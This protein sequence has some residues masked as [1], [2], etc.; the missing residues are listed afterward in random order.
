MH[1]EGLFNRHSDLLV[2]H[3]GTQTVLYDAWHAA[4]RLPL[5]RIDVLSGG[6]ALTNPQSLYTYPWHVLFAPYRPE[7]VIGLVIWLDLV[8][9]ALGAY[10]AATV[11]RLSVSARLLVAIATLFSFKTILAV[12]A[13]WLTALPGIA[14]IPWLLG[15]AVAVLE[16]PSWRSALFLGLVGAVSLHTG[17]LQQVYY[18]GLLLGVWSMVRLAQQAATAQYG[19]ATRTAVCL[20]LGAIMAFSLSAYLIIPL[21][22][23][24][25]LVTRSAGSYG[26]FIGS[27]PFPVRALLTLLDPEV[28]GTPL[29]GTFIEAWEYVIYLGAIPSL[30]A[31]VGA[32]RGRKRPLVRVLSAGL[33]LTVLLALQTPL[34]W[35]VYGIVPGYGL[36]RLPARIL[37]VSA[38]F[39]FCLAG[40]GLD[41]ILS[42]AR[43]DRSRRVVAVV[44]IGLVCVEGT[45]W[46]RR[47]LRT[48]APIPPVVAAP[49]LDV[50][51]TRDQAARIAPLSR[52]IPNYGSAASLG[53][54]LVAGGDPFNLRH[55]QTY[56]DLLQSNRA[57]GNRPAGWTDV[58]SVARLDMLAALNVLYVVAPTRVALPTSEYA[59]VDVFEDQAQFRFYEGVQSGPVYIYR[60][61]RFLGRAFFATDVR[62]AA[63]ADEAVRLIQTVDV[64]E[65]AIVEASDAGDSLATAGDRVD[66][67]RS[68]GGELDLAARNSTRRFL[69]ISEVWHPGWRARMDGQSVPLYRS[70]IALQGVWLTP[71][72]HRIEL[73]Y[74]PPGLT[75]GLTIT[76]FT[77][78][79]VV[80]LLVLAVMKRP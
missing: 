27:N 72:E 66:V 18:I 43:T 7:R 40:V 25:A 13:G 39:G 5:W 64:R 6:P 15:S 31:I 70:D 34:L 75:L 50:L 20:L 80:G 42:R 63:D 36:F 3:L 38:F 55:Y 10:Y 37:F 19:N 30:L 12:Y 47:Y 4:H 46:A 29:D 56:M 65:T 59:L 61:Q 60:N 9:A 54:Q 51:T 45:V 68:A 78:T 14:A 11:L 32:A 8:V 28:F 62:T 41:E 35:I 22:R 79:C 49:Y 57:S 1:P 76:A 17:H 73:R 69:V 52:S 44:L 2:Y 16:R 58:T 74:W 24:A 67:V 21:A 71:G 48:S 33:V 26:F 23:D 77:A 53:L